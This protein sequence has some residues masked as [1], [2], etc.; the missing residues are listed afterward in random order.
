MDKLLNYKLNNRPLFLL[1]ALLYDYFKYTGFFFSCPLL[2]LAH[3][4]ENSKK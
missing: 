1:K 2:S 3:N 4:F